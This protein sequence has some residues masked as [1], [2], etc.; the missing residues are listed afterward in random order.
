MNDSDLSYYSKKSHRYCCENCDYTWSIENTS[1][2]ESSEVSIEYEDS[3]DYEEE[4]IC[5][6]CGSRNINEI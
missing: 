6:M 4:F 3:F 2:P 1:D 5:P